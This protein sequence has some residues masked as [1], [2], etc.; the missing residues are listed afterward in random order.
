MTNT[1]HVESGR[2]LRSVMT[3]L[4]N[5]PR[6]YNIFPKKIEQGRPDGLVG[7]GNKVGV[8]TGQCVGHCVK[9]ARSIL[10]GKVEAKELADPLM[11]R[12]GRQPLIQQEL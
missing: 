1:N 8:A 2:A 11:L 7:G 6:G 3:V 10:D 12:H 4:R 5:G 9:A